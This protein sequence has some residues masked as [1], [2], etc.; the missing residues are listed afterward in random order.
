MNDT[1][2]KPEKKKAFPLPVLNINFSLAPADQILPCSEAQQ[3][4]VLGWR[5]Q[6]VKAVNTTFG[7]YKTLPMVCR[8]GDCFWASMCPTAPDFMFEGLLCPLETREVFRTF[9][10]YIQELEVEP[11]DHVDLSLIVDLVRIDLQLKR[12]DQQVQIEGMHVSHVAGVVQKTG[13]ILR[14]EIPHTLLTFQRGLRKDRSNIYK[15]LLAS[16][17]ARKTIELKESRETKNFLDLISRVQKVALPNQEPKML[18]ESGTTT[19][20]TDV[21]FTFDLLGGDE[22]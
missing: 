10:R 8:A 21:E 5:V 7:L 9:V 1:P 3:A 2:G 19:E 16:R 15:E 17:E 14:E 12:I 13:E 4:K 20:T 18:P 6:D 22:E 11:E